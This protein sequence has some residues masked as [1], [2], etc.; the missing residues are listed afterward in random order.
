MPQ[1]RTQMGNKKQLRIRYMPIMQVQNKESETSMNTR[2]TDQPVNIINSGNT[3]IAQ[4]EQ[5]FQKVVMRFTK[6]KNK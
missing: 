2:T 1:M 6:E 5:L 3:T 4:G